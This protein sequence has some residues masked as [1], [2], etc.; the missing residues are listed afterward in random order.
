MNC[1]N[2]E[3]DITGNDV[4]ECESC[5]GYFCPDH[6]KETAIGFVCDDDIEMLDLAVIDNDNS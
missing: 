4:I 3:L 2:C 5:G 1:E 6:V